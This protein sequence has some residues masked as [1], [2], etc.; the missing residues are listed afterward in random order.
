MAANHILVK[1]VISEQN[2]Q[3]LKLQSLSTIEDLKELVKQKANLKTDFVLQYLDEDVKD[4]FNLDDIENV[5]HL[6][7]IKVVRH[8]AEK[9]ESVSKKAETALNPWP[10]TFPL[11]NFETAVIKTSLEK[12]ALDFSNGELTVVPEMLRRKIVAS[13]AEEII[14]FTFYPSGKDID[15]MCRSLI[16]QYPYLKDLGPGGYSTWCTCVKFRI[17]NL[18]KSLKHTVPEI[19]TNS[20]KRS[21]ENPSAPSPHTSIKKQRTG[22]V[23]VPRNVMAADDVY[24]SKLFLGTEL[25]KPEPNFRQ[26]W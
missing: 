17:G 10:S 18:R 26:V 8:P 9:T 14:K 25:M 13:M 11:P 24:E 4:F 12:L 23:M 16:N 19:A 22:T 21:K 3:K 20:G 1:L 5:T 6:G 7:T 2:V 15:N